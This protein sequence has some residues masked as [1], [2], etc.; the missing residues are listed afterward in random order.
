MSFL[1]WLAI[2]RQSNS[3]FQ[4]LQSFESLTK[5]NLVLTLL[6]IRVDQPWLLNPRRIMKP[7]AIETSKKYYALNNWSNKSTW[8]ILINFLP[9][10]VITYK[11]WVQPLLIIIIIIIVS[12]KCVQKWPD[13]KISSLTTFQTNL[14]PFNYTC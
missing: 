5:N 8:W 4:N 12:L 3:S 13:S 6:F 7:S 11:I 1:F 10:F 14:L 2:R 9:K